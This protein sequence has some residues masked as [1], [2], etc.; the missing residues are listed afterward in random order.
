MCLAFVCVYRMFS[1]HAQTDHAS[2]EV[3]SLTQ[4]IDRDCIFLST[5]HVEKI[6]NATYRQYQS[7]VGNFALWQ[8][9]HAI[10]VQQAGN[11]DDFPGAIKSTQFALLKYEVMPA[12]LRCVFQLMGIRIHTAGC[13]F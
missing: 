5:R 9:L 11:R 8:E 13:D 10:V 7:I 12:R 6:S 1:T 2:S 3:F 4:G